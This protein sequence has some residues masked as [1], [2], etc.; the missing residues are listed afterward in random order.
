MDKTEAKCV[1]EALLFASEKPISVDQIKEVLSEFDSRDIRTLLLEL[2][3][4]Y[5]NLGR[6][7]KIYE[8]AGGFQM[9]TE[10]A[11]AEYL[12]LFYKAKFKDKLT[13]PALETLAIIAYRQPVTRAD[14]EDIRGVNVDGVI[15]TL[16]ERTLIRIVGRKDAP[17]RPIIYGTTKEF[18][19]RFGLNSLS[20]LPKLFEFTEADIDLSEVHSGGGNSEGEEAKDGTGEVTQENRP[21]G[22][23]D[24]TAAQRE[25][26][27]EQKDRSAESKE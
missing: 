22:L 24:N 16:M 25:S 15:K 7:F 4:E 8:I 9:A 12:K 10:P 18:L 2:K 21:A 23:E 14:I 6:S 5:E 17:G 13:R 1:I 20:E 26:P 3:S 27:L 11:Y 19:D